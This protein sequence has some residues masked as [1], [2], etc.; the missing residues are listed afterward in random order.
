MTESNSHGRYL[1]EGIEQ[2]I[3]PMITSVD[4]YRETRE[5]SSFPF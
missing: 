3:L 1:H 4:P 2:L 5:V